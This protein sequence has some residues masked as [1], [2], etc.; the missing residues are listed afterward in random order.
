M[1]NQLPGPGPGPS[2]DSILIVNLTRDSQDNAVWD[3]TAG[4]VFSAIEQKIIILKETNE[5]NTEYYS[6]LTAGYSPDT[7]EYSFIDVNTTYEASSSTDYPVSSSS[8]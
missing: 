1:L 7:D 4:E 5:E 6:L 2:G 8:N 3:K